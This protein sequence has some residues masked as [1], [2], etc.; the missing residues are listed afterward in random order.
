MLCKS[1]DEFLR[2]RNLRHEG[3]NEFNLID[4]K[5]INLSMLTF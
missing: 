3:V 4:E 1:M 5:F 2:D